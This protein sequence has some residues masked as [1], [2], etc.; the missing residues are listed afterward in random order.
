MHLRTSPRMRLSSPFNRVVIT[1]IIVF[2]LLLISTTA[3]F[4]QTDADIP[5]P[6]TVQIYP[7]PQPPTPN[8]QYCVTG[9]VINHAEEPMEGWTVTATYEGVNGSYAP[10]TTE[11]DASGRFSFDLPGPGRWRIEVMFQDPWESVTSPSMAVHVG[12]GNMDCVE[13]R[14]KLRELVEVIV[15]KID[16]EHVPQAGWTILATPDS[17]NT[18]AAVQTSVTDQNGEA[19]FSLT[20]GKWVFSEDAPTGVIF[21]RPISPPS[22][23]HF[24]DVQG[25]NTIILRFKNLIEKQE[26]G[27]IDVRK[28]DSPPDPNDEPFGLAGWTIEVVRADGAIAASGETDANGWASFTNLKFGPYTVHEIMQSGWVA[29]SPTSYSVVLTSRDDG[30]AQITFVNKQIPKGYCIT[31]R[32]LDA[33]GMVGIP[34]WEIMAVPTEDGDPAPDAVLTDGSGRYLICLPF[35]DYRVPGSVYRITEVIPAGW[36]AVSATEYYVTLPEHPESPVEAPDFVNRQSTYPASNPI[37]ATPSTDSCQQS[38]GSCSVIHTVVPG[39]S[40]YK[41]ASN[42][43]VCASSIFSANAWISGQCNRWLYVGQKVCIP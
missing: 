42:Y 1:S 37:G 31:G 29:A 7:D 8:N 43:G 21:W 28:L 33:N 38:C 11:S 15:I 23:K 40:V 36:D 6:E 9:T 22:G 19:A 4:A 14:F 10:I 12:F 34:D 27:C 24:I 26:D 41:L 35:E 39:D 32:K 17:G 25:P 13:I 30:C 20:P 3:V 18:F 16:D 2:V 5:D